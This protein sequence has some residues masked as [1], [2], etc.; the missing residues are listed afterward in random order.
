MV[1]III[2]KFLTHEEFQRKYRLQVSFLR[3]FQILSSI[4]VSLKGLR[5]RAYDVFHPLSDDQSIMRC[6]DY[7][8]FTPTATTTTT[9]AVT[10]WSKH[11]INIITLSGK[12]YLRI[13]Q[14]SLD[15][16]LRHFSCKLLHRILS[17]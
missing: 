10:T 2:G 12:K 3:Y 16:K 6:K 15:N 9:T 17:N 8:N 14:L 13:P 7:Y 1:Y 4:S 5:I 11:N